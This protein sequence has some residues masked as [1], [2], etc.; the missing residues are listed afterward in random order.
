MLTIEVDDVR[1]EMKKEGEKNF[2]PEASDWLNDKSFRANQNLGRQHIFYV[3]SRNANN[4]LLAYS[5]WDS[6]E[7][8][9]AL[10]IFP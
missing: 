3:N 7:K 9:D 2:S 10:G 4:D 8:N 6:E 1:V 5:H